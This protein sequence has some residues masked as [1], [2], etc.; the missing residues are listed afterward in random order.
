MQTIWITTLVIGA[1]GLVCGVLLSVVAKRFA[2]RENPLIGQLLEILP[3]ANCGGCGRPG[4]DG[5]A[6]DIA[7]H[8]AALNLCT[9]C[10]AE[11]IAA[12]EALTGRAAGAALERKVAFVRC[13]GDA[14]AAKRRFAY[15]G[16]ADCGA[17]HATA[18]GDKGCTYGC[19]GYGSC[20]RVCPYQAIRVVN[21]VA[22]VDEGKCVGCGA[23]VGACPRNV[24]ELVPVTHR[25]RVA[26]ASREKGPKVRKVCAKGCLGC[27]LCAKVVPGVFLF[28]G[29]LATVDYSK[30]QASAEE[31]AKVVQKCPG[32]CIQETTR[33]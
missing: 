29:A 13:A 6:R 4:C 20:E 7:E 3:G 25:M 10:S 1:I 18:G 24:I 17:V 15:N 8:G 19:L 30:A 32:H 16:I 23:C 26:C 2:V 9:A 22:V 14:D 11:M 28:D 27:G 33:S 5:Y 31:V 21:G 12:M